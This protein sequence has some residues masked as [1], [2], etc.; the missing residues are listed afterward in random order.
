MV[1]ACLVF[2][3]I[4]VSFSLLLFNENNLQNNNKDKENIIN[5]N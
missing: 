4:I 3:E 1:I 2:S 5:E